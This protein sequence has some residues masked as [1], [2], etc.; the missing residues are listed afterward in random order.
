MTTQKPRLELY[1]TPKSQRVY[2]PYAVNL[3]DMRL[4]LQRLAASIA[5][6]ELKIPLGAANAYAADFLKDKIHGCTHVSIHP[7]ART[8]LIKTVD[9]AGATYEYSTFVPPEWRS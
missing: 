6:G 9:P 5:S 2:Q 4:A 3:R 7:W 8:L 1:G